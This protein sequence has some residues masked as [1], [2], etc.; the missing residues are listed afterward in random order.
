MATLCC[1][2]A[3]GSGRRVVNPKSEISRYG[4]SSRCTLYPEP[5]T[6]Y[7]GDTMADNELIWV[8]DD[9]SAIRE[10]LSFIVTEAGYTVDTFSSPI[11][12]DRPMRSSSI[13]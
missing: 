10:L 8:V 6:L 1:L 2:R 4:W 11:P 5:C 12:A 3:V 9:D 7:P 13:S